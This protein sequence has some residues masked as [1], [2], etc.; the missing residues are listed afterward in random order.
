MIAMSRDITC[1]KNLQNIEDL[2]DLMEKCNKNKKEQISRFPSHFYLKHSQDHT[3][4]RLQRTLRNF[5]IQSSEKLS[6]PKVMEHDIAAKLRS[7]L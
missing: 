4:V 3:Q 6:T 5:L 7:E 1:I 2:E